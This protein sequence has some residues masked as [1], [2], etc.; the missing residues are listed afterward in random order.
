MEIITVFI[1]DVFKVFCQLIINALQML[2]II[3]II[4]YEQPYAYYNIK[5]SEESKET[6]KVLKF[7]EYPM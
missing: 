4:I 1:S 2:P 6:Y 7:I 3:N 5:S